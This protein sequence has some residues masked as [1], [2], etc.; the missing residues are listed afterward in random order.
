MDKLVLLT[1]LS[2]LLSLVREFPLVA[3]AAFV[4]VL[5]FYVKTFGVGPPGKSLTQKSPKSAR[6]YINELPGPACLPLLGNSL[7]M[8][9]DREG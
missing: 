9:T 4:G 6:Q 8:A 5:F 3:T 2:Q 1:V 7:M